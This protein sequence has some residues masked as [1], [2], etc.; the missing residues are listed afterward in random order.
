MLT[1]DE[2]KHQYTENGLIIPS[3]TQIIEAAGLSDLTW[4]PKEVL[5]EKSD[6]G[7]KVHK[8]TELYDLGILDLDSLHETLRG[9]LD[10]WIKFR[11]D[12]GFEPEEIEKQCF[13][14]L[15]KFA[16][17]VDRVGKRILVDIKSGTKQKSHAIQT[18]GYKILFD[19][20]RAKSESI[21]ERYA[22]YLKEDGYEVEPHKNQNDLNVFLAALTIYNF[23]KGAK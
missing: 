16:G 21:K 2:T 19:C 7:K 10:S 1:F 15:Y 11:K 3:V 6:L 23:K 17:R 12:Y 22:V 20:E 5:E 18:M 9:Y 13:H 14:P 8:T 4:I